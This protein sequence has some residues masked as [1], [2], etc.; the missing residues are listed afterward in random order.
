MY[1]YA[2]LYLDYVQLNIQQEFTA[3]QWP[4]CFLFA[5]LKGVLEILECVN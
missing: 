3:I 5:A 4:Q 1:T 2:S